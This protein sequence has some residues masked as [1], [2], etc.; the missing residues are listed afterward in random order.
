MGS[1][2]QSFQGQ[3]GLVYSVERILQERPEISRYTVSKDNYTYYQDIYERLRSCENLRV[4]CDS[5]S[6]PPIFI[7]KYLDDHLLSFAQENPELPIIKR[8]LKDALRGLAALHDQDIVHTDIKPNNI[9]IFIQRRG[10]E[11]T[12]VRLADL[13]DSAI[14]PQGSAI[15]GR[16]MGNWMWRSPEAHAEGPMNKPSDMFSF[17]IVCL[18]AVLKRVILYVGEEEIG[19]G[20]EVLAH[21]IERQ[22]SF[23]ADKEGIMAFLK[24]LGDSPWVQ[25]FSVIKDGFNAENRRKPLYLWKNV[26]PDLRDLIGKLT[27]FDPTKRLRAREALCHPWFEDV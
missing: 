2:P 12:E 5:V 25:I 16:Q 10:S 22:I 27:S 6:D 1:P 20:E 8:I 15:I 14:V 17:G 7:Y 3:S 18:Y 11:V 13:E 26:D 9:F 21:V 19:E 4:A 24:Y 23:F